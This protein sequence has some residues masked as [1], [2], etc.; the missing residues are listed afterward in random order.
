MWE[1]LTR[2]LLRKAADKIGGRFFNDEANGPEAYAD[3]I[4]RDFHLDDYA[5]AW[6]LYNSDRAY[7]E[8]YYSAL[9]IGP[10]WH[11]E[12][13]RDSTAAAGV[14]SRNNVF[15]YGFPESTSAQPSIREAVPPPKPTPAFQPDA[16]Y[17]PDGNF[18]GNFSSTEAFG[19]RYGKWGSVPIGVA[20]PPAPDRPG[21]FDNRFGNWGSVPAS[22]SGDSGSPVLRALEK[23]RRS[24][25]PDGPAPISAQGALPATPAS[26]PYT[27]GTGGVLGKFFLD[28]PITP[29]EAASPLAQGAPLLRPYF[30]GATFGDRSGN[31]PG[32]PSPDTYPQLRRVSSAFPG[33]TPPGPVQLVPPSQPG[34][35]LGIFTGKPM[36]SWTTPPPLGGLLNNSSASGNGDLV[37]FLAGLASRNQTP[38]E[39]LQQTADS[40]PE[41]RLGRRTYSVSPASV[42]D[43]GAPEVPFVSSG[44]ANY[45]GGLLGMFAALAGSDPKQP[46]PPDDE[47]E[48]ANLQA[49]EAK[50]SSSGN[51]NDAWAL[52]NARKAV[53]P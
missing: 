33:M 22:A 16:T 6:A 19:D 35:P 52:Y 40:I 26:Q 23:Y 51:I 7:W 30:P 37:D 36:P 5:D 4:K 34:R 46:A 20:Q 49:L 9:P 3:R 8:R 29:A 24:A 45:P 15:E 28:S 21:S 53:R 48:Q 11:Q 32:A 41:R 50:L 27:A 10:D 17:A 1:F 43:T 2:Q 44:D 38:P 31:T 47:Q 12:F 25:A 42:F 14:P 39:P 13:I 18:Y